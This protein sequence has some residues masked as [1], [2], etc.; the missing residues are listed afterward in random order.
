MGVFQK[1]GQWYIDYYAQGQR[2]RERVGLSKRLAER[3]LAARRGEIAQ[4]R[5][6]L[7]QVRRSPRFEEAAREYLA[8][9]QTNHRSW[10]W[11]LGA[12]K[13]LLASFQGKTLREITPWL[14]EK[15]KRERREALVHGRPIRP[16]TVNRELACLK[17]LFTLAIQ[18]GK[19]ESNPV[20]GVKFFPEDGR[21]ERILTPEEIH[22]LLA[23]CTDHSRPFVL[24]ALNTGMRR[25]EILE[26]IWDRVDVE[27]G[28]ITLTRTKSGKGRRVPLNDLMRDTL[29]RLPRHGPYVFGGARPFG[30]IKT[31]FL[32][33]CRRAGITGCR[34]HDLRHTAATYMVLGGQDLATVQEILG[35]STVTLTMRYTHPTPESKRRAVASLEALVAAGTGHQVDTRAEGSLVARRVTTV[36]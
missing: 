32:A 23:A 28:V 29:R 10:Q 35:H 15:Y 25:G 30:S 36:K 24:L 31:A 9:A 34:F 6:N 16:P 8:W 5:F 11:E 3:A 1:Q 18:W 19:A 4:G 13:H 27:Q 12:I 7:Q 20:R 17:R 33:A 26:L 14:V 21:R 2:I 22:R